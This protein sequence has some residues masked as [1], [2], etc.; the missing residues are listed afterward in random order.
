MARFFAWFVGL[1]VMLFLLELTPPVQAYLVMPWT[2][3]LATI[4]TS[5]AMTTRFAID[6]SSV[7]WGLRATIRS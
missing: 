5:I 3:M 2:N 6:L 1:L 7:T 4:S